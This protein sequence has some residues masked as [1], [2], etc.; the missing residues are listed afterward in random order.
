V[1]RAHT[2]LNK[3]MSKWT[4][5]T[6][7]IVMALILEVAHAAAAPPTLLKFSVKEIDYY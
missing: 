6:L 1:C 2:M 3:Y 4:G 7:Y 5:P